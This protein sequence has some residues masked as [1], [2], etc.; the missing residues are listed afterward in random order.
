MRK[1]GPVRFVFQQLYCVRRNFFCNH[2]LHSCRSAPTRLSVFPL[3]GLFR[4]QIRP[5]SVQVGFAA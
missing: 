1:H 3:K 5:L 4:S 2:Y